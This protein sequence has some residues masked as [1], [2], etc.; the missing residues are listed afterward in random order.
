VPKHNVG[1]I[2]ANVE[3]QRSSSVRSGKIGNSAL[4]VALKPPSMCVYPLVRKMT[5]EPSVHGTGKAASSLGQK[6]W[7]VWWSLLA[8]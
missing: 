7:I 2:S 8:W 5:L 3:R 4:V 1:G 6:S